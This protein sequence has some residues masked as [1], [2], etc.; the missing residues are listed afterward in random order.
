MLALAALSD[1]DRRRLAYEVGNTV[2]PRGIT[3]P[4]S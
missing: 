3:A 2:K 4:G 1:E